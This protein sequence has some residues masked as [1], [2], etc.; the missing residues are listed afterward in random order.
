MPR[1][2]FRRSLV[3]IA[4]ASQLAVRA[5][6]QPHS[7]ATLALAT[8]ALSTSSALAADEIR[9]R[10][11][12]EAAQAEAAESGRPLMIH[13]TSDHCVPCRMLEQGAFVDRA[14]VDSLSRAVVP[15][16]VNV[17]QHRGI[18]D[19]YNIQRWPTDLFLH[20][21]G[22]EIHRGVSPQKPEVYIQV[23]ERVA[24]KNRDWVAE[25]MAS[26]KGR[27]SMPPTRSAPAANST[28]ATDAPRSS[29]GNVPPVVSASTV[30]RSDRFRTVASAKPASMEVN[31]YCLPEEAAT[32]LGAADQE[33]AE[34]GL[35]SAVAMAAA[36]AARTNRYQAD[37]A[38]AAP[39]D[40]Q[41][42]KWV[43]ASNPSPSM[44]PATLVASGER[45]LM[46]SAP[47]MAAT[48][49]APG[50]STNGMAR[51]ELSGVVQEDMQPV[52]DGCCPVLLQQNSSWTTGS[53]AFAV[54]HRGRIYHC[55]SEEA[56]QAFLQQPDA[57]SPVLSGYDVVHFLETG[58]LVPGAR[59]HGLW[60]RDR[61]F[62]FAS[63]ENRQRFDQSSETTSQY[64]QHLGIDRAVDPPVIASPDV[65]PAMQPVVEG[66]VANGGSRSTLQR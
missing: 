40:A 7:L 1:S 34:A 4:V 64:A 42:L 59:E 46:A 27:P 8:A 15:V 38:Q 33:G 5:L 26:R 45:S 66:R 19:Q 28:A 50:T 11:D 31:P 17:D 44:T 22:D 54:K 52:F 23:L 49:A 55:C 63:A 20:P 57:Y 21:N 39:A 9:W 35:D 56:R 36:T 2:L 30:K 41:Q 24:V 61:V 62:L 14:V 43:A 13:F 58:E 10:T 6:A 3:S 25:R 16:M 51:A 53:S 12:L 48:G 18:A 60:F 37:P 32:V 47:A 65:A 29:A